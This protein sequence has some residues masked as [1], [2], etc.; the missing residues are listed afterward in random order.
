M[1]WSNK[2]LGIPFKRGG[3]DFNGC[4]CWGLLR[5]VFERELNVVLPP[6]PWPMPVQWEQVHDGWAD[7]DVCLWTCTTRLHVGVLV[8]G[9]NFLHAP[10][11]M[12]VCVDRL[13]ATE[14]NSLTGVYRVR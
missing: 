5:L 1:S 11:D 7:F 12:T 8:G 13:G 10:H 3:A 6:Q 14:R 2:Y 4:D 9:R